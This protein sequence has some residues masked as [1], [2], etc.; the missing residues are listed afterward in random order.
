[1]AATAAT[2]RAMRGSIYPYETAAGVRYY[3]KYR[4]A[5]GKQSTK[6]GF[7]T[8]TAARRARERLMGRVHRREVSVSRE[9][10]AGYWTRYLAAHRPYLDHTHQQPHL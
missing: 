5:S 10:L 4:D 9:T 1:M 6:R 7:T 2:G 8:E 3:V